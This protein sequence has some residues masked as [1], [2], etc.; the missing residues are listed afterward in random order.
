M[1]NI[2]YIVITKSSM[3][4]PGDERSRT[5]PGHG[6]PERYEEV[7][8][9]RRLRSKQELESYILAYGEKDAEIYKVQPVKVTRHVSLA[10]N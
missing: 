9:V 5:N 3:Y 7:Q 1:D 10:I 6:Y 2:E 4:I 8:N